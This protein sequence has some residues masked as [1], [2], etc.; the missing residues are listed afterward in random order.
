MSKVQSKIETSKP[1]IL[2]Q[3][4]QQHSPKIEGKAPL[5]TVVVNKGVAVK[6]TAK[7]PSSLSPSKNN[8]VA[9]PKRMKIDQNP[10]YDELPS[11]IEEIQPVSNPSPVKI[12]KQLLQNLPKKIT[13]K[14]LEK[15]TVDLNVSIGDNTIMSQNKLL[16]LIEVTPDQ[17]EKLNQKLSAAERSTKVENLISSFL[18]NDTSD[19]HEN[20]N[21]NV[22][23]IHDTIIT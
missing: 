22:F 7:R 15:P 13:N 18:D 12:E 9:T 23:K 10:H 21:G 14:V 5:L 6:N 4:Y 17:Y 20:E 1:T 16:A 11:L 8:K 2:N 19:E 3:N